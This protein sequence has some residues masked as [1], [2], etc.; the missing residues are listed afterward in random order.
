MSNEKITERF[1]DL[2]CSEKE[3]E[4]LQAYLFSCLGEGKNH[5]LQRNRV[6]IM[7][8]ENKNKYIILEL[9]R[10]SN[11]NKLCY[12]CPKCFPVKYAEFLSSTI[13][14]D[15]FK[16][17]IHTKLCNL[18]WGDEY[19]LQIDIVDDDLEDDLV[20]I[21]SEKPQYMAAIHPSQKSPKG[22]GVVIIHN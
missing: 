9:V 6:M 19:D 15:K 12:A 22:P 18:I 21:I 4:L 11:E 3:K 17:C 14:A 5:R 1:K 13:P 10:T 16:S 8:E 7:E 2:A 20:E